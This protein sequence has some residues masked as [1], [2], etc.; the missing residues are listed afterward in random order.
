ML[1]LHD[2]N[3]HYYSLLLKHTGSGWCKKVINGIGIVV[4]CNGIGRT[5]QLFLGRDTTQDEDTLETIVGAKQNVRVE[6]IADHANA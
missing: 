4:G 5:Q 6:P 2:G 3:H 1:V